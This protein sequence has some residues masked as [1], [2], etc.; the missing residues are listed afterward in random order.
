MSV[1]QKILYNG[2]TGGSCPNPIV[3]DIRYEQVS[4]RRV[5]SIFSQPY[6]QVMN[7]NIK[8]LIFFNILFYINNFSVIFL[9]YKFEM[10]DIVAIW[11]FTPF[12]LILFTTSMIEISNQTNLKPIKK[13]SLI[14]FLIRVIVLIINF[15]AISELIYLKLEYLI[16][17]EVIFML[18]NIT[19]ELNIYKKMSLIIYKD[20]TIDEDL[21]S[22]KEVNDLIKDLAN[23]QTILRNKF[24]DEKEEILKSYK[25]TSIMG[26]SNLLMLLLIVGGVIAFELFGE[27]HGLKVLLVALLLVGIYFHLTNK[28]FTLFY[29]DDSNQI[30]IKLRDNTSFL[31]GLTIIYVLHG[32]IYVGTGTF[33]FLES[34]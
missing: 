17:I 2:S 31:F 23:E 9:I 22:S 13:L 5:I 21:L 6:L 26:Y 12:I 33:N 11:F 7:N 34:S 19:I 3:K 8:K 25:L 29:G 10:I 24:P 1:E 20:K 28:K 32:Y 4:T 14:D 18:V 15:L 30:K 27:V 16:L